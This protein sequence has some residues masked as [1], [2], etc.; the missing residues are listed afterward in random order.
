MYLF[1]ENA[2]FN[3]DDNIVEELGNFEREKCLPE[4]NMGFLHD[5]EVIRSSV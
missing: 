1:R 5:D 4:E 2:I 3:D